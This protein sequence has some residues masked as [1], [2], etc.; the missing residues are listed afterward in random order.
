VSEEES[1]VGIVGV[2]CGFG[3]FVVGSVIPYPVEDAGLVCDGVADHEEGSEGKG[4]GEGSVGPQSVCSHCY[5]KA[6]NRPKRKSKQ[7]G[8][9]FASRNFSNSDDGDDV[10]ESG[11]CRHEPIHISLFPMMVHLRGYRG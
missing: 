8:C 5:S 9:C 1:P 11:P 7:Q 10:D 6:T 2:G 4:C 3:V